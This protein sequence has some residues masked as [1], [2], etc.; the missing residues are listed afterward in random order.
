MSDQDA[1]TPRVFLV[2]HGE[3]EWAKSGRFTGSTEMELTQPG[4]AQVRSTAS[5]LVGT[6]KLLDPYRLAHVFVSPRVRAV[7]TFELLLPN[8]AI[9]V[10]ENVTYTDDITE[11][12]YG[13]YEGLKDQEI[14]A[15]RKSKGLDQEKEWD[16]WSD[17]C[18]GGESCQ[19][20]TERLHRVISKIKEIHT[21]FMR[22][23]KPVDV[24]LVAHGLILRCF[25]K[26]WIGLPIHNPLPMILSPGAIAILSY[27]NNDINQPALHTGLALPCEEYQ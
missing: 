9:V 13:N 21:P 2:R 10:P 25:I 16:I 15:L 5:K 12:D 23:E 4:I 3:T 1:L 20:V 22:G 7:K 8:P 27:K 18:E 14:R 17:G 6:G 24:L 19:Q 26:L 11:W